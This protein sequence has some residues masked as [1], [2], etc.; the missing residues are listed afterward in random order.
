MGVYPSKCQQCSE[1]FIWF[2]GSMAQICEDCQSKTT[3]NSTNFFS[4]VCSVCS[5]GFFLN[6]P[7]T[8]NYVI[9]SNCQSGNSTL[10]IVKGSNTGIET[11]KHSKE[12][13]YLLN[14]T[15][16]AQSDL[17]KYLKEVIESL[18]KSLPVKSEPKVEFYTYPCPPTYAP[19]NPDLNGGPTIDIG[20]VKT[21]YINAQ[22][23]EFT[24][25]EVNGPYGWI[26]YYVTSEGHQ[27]KTGSSE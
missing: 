18:K 13:E 6:K 2:S 20:G 23:P 17:I 16:E 12:C 15:I 19:S 7:S 21:P 10:E 26:S 3:R 9:C 22:G 24:K 1:S 14:K 27:I 8:S 4:A 11:S 5:S 25:V